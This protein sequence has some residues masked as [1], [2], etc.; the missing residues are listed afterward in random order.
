MKKRV[1]QKIA[2]IA[3]ATI[4]GPVLANDTSCPKLTIIFVIDQL[5]YD[6]L[7]T[8]TPYVKDGFKRLLSRGVE[9]TNAHH[10][11]GMPATCTG[12][13]ALSTGAYGTEH[14]IV[15]NSWFN[16]EGNI[17]ACDDASAKDAAVLAPHGTYEYGKSFHYGMVDGIS[18]QFI[19]RSSPENP[20]HAYGISLKSRAAIA[21]ANSA[22]IALWFDDQ[23]GTFTSSKAYV[24]TLPEWVVSFNKE[25]AVVSPSSFYWAQ[26]YPDNAAAYNFFHTDD[27][28]YIRLQKPLVN[29]TIS[30][31]PDVKEDNH[32]HLFSI[33]P[34]ANKLVFDCAVACMQATVDKQKPDTLLLWVCVSS[35][36]KLGHQFGPWSK[37]TIDMLYHLDTQIGEVMDAAETLIDPESIVYA[38]TSDHGIAPIVEQL[39]ERGVHLGRRIE[40]TELIKDLNEYIEREYGYANLVYGTKGHQLYLNTKLLRKM[41]HVQRKK[42]IRDLQ[43][44]LESYD[45]IKKAWTHEEL[46]AGNFPHYSAEYYFRQQL[47]KQRSGTLIMQVYP[48]TIISAHTYGTSHKTP[49]THNTHVPLVL[50]QKN[51]I[52]NKKVNT[53]VLTLQLAPTLAQILGTSQPSAAMSDVLPQVLPETGIVD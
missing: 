6:T 40:S 25:H 27:Y 15:G 53:K 46:N 12:H 14:G 4:A 13:T 37:E 1:L 9:F 10:P 41:P 23:S 31:G 45:G 30:I 3:T 7:R 20:R 35:L 51:K 11:H 48:Y 17:V 50:Y 43:D 39:H 21:T 18:D 36:D 34:H 52:Q 5:A 29:T 33:T 19:L 42:V 38:L 44:V 22:G 32:Y 49:Y 47:F 16:A 26:K 28:R 2:L 24:H 8:V